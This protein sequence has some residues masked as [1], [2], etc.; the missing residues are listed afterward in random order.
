MK[1]SGPDPTATSEADAAGLQS[2]LLRGLSA[3]DRRLR[4]RRGLKSLTWFAPAACLWL[5]ASWL[6]ALGATSEGGVAAHW[7][8]WAGGAVLL[9]LAL[10]ETAALGRDLPAAAR[11]VDRVGD[12]HDAVATA[13]EMQHWLDDSRGDRQREG[14]GTVWPLPWIALVLQRAV[15]GLERTGPRQTVPRLVPRGALPSAGISLLLLLPVALPR[16]FVGEALASA[17]SGDATGE[18]PPGF[19]AA[20]LLEDDPNRMPGIPELDVRLSDLPLVTLR[21]REPNAEDG[22]RSGD[23]TDAAEGSLGDGAEAETLD[24]SAEGGDAAANALTDETNPETGADLMRELDN[25]EG[26]GEE[27]KGTAPGTEGSG[28][29]TE[30]SAEAGEGDGSGGQPVE[31]GEGSGDESGTAAAVSEEPGS[32]SGEADGAAAGVGT[33]PQEEMVD[34]FGDLLV[35]ALSLEQALETALLESIEEIERRPLATTSATQFRAAEVAMRGAAPAVVAQAA[36]SS[37]DLPS[38]RRP[39]AWRHR[40]SV[41]RYLEALEAEVEEDGE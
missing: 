5:L 36:A 2:R 12:L 8:S 40:E 13:L 32:S 21:V 38:A 33:G 35:P 20:A 31:D 4:L 7:P 17:M 16:S 24:A 29:G 1:P 39:I 34:P 37:G 23:S 6:L 9:L 30:S 22:S 26:T 25:R 11:A 27:E 41:R 3:T 14:H 10:R 18:L 19:E 28:E 15:A